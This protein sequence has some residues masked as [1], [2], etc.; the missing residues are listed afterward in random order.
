MGAAL[1]ASDLGSELERRISFERG[2]DFVQEAVS[3]SLLPGI[4]TKA[5]EG[6]RFRMQTLAKGAITTGKGFEWAGMECGVFWSELPGICN[7]FFS[8]AVSPLVVVVFLLL[9][10]V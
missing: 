7:T 6:G 10:L 3:L 9:W 1:G 5:S 8:L 2:G 4:Q